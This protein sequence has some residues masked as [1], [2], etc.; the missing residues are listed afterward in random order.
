MQLQSENNHVFG[1]G[2]NYSMNFELTL[3]EL[4]RNDKSVPIY[5]V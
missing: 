1:I 4:I 5:L 2:N 3:I